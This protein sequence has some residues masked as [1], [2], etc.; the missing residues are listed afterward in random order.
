MEFRNVFSKWA[1]SIVLIIFGVIVTVLFGISFINTSYVSYDGTEKIYYTNDFFGKHIVAII[2]IFLILIWIRKAKQKSKILNKIEKENKKIVEICLIAIALIASFLVLGGQ[3]IPGGDQGIVIQIANQ[4]LNRDFTS[5]EIGEYLYQYPHQ[6][7]HVV[8]YMLPCFLF[9]D[10]GVI[11]IQLGNVGMVVISIWYTWKITSKMFHNKTIGIVTVLATGTFIP[12]L[13]Y[14]TFVYG[15]LIGH[16]LSLCAIWYQWKWF[17]SKKKL[18]VFIT[19]ITIIIAVL[20][21]SNYLI[22]M[23]AIVIMYLWEGIEKKKFISIAMGIL[24]VI[25]Y[26]VSNFALKSGVE[27]YTGQDMPKGIPQIAWVSMGL[28]EGSRASGWYNGYTVSSFKANQYDTEAT[29]QSA[30]QAIIES[31]NEFIQNPSYMVDFFTRKIASEWSEPS[32]QG[33]WINEIRGYTGQLNVVTDLFSGTTKKVFIE[34]FDIVQTIIYFGTILWVFFGKAK[35]KKESYILPIVF[36]GGFIFH[37][38]WEGKGQYTFTYFVLLIPYAVAGFLETSDRFYNYI[39]E[40][41]QI[42]CLELSLRIILLISSSMLIAYGLFSCVSV[43][44]EKAQ[45]QSF[46]FKPK[47]EIE[48]GMYQITTYEDSS[49]VLGETSS[50]II[51]TKKE[52][53]IENINTQTINIDYQGGK[54]YF[55]F[56]SSNKALDV[57]DGKA[58]EN[59]QVQQYK[60][61][62]TR[63]QQWKI[64][65]ADNGAYYIRYNEYYVLSWDKENNMAVL[66]KFTGEDS[67]KWKFEKY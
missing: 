64:E 29:S 24:I 54:Y 10:Y 12:F 37:L 16:T 13:L 42:D 63:A 61:L 26:F 38:F 25:C 51:V 30:K 17:E 3:V 33:F 23:C 44:H 47:Q 45:I 6:I 4:F 15:N 53:N 20:I 56:E 18:Y 58:G 59:T 22:P 40:K 66:K 2:A 55:T 14:V 11:A 43:V 52:E 27:W 62:K 49:M 32:F 48:N 65:P 36:I 28:Q 7:G 60:L 21:K 1:R 8:A 39:T 5:L 9:G 50:A 57:P 34:I 19:F 46:I 31:V 35:H 41:K 67:Q